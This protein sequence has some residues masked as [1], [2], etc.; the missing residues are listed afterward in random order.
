M[1]TTLPR[2]TDHDG[3]L[4]HE[5]LDSTKYGRPEQVILDFLESARDGRQRSDVRVLD[6]GCGRGS[7]VAWL[8]EA[9][10]DAWGADVVE[11]YLVAGKPFFGRRG[12]NPDRLRLIDGVGLPFSD[13]E[14]FDVVLSDQVIEHV[15]DLDAFV[16][17]IDQVSR[18]SAVGMHIFPATWR[19]VEPHLHQP[20]VHWFPKGAPRHVA[21][22][23]ATRA[24]LGTDY[25]A[26]LS[27]RDRAQI[28]TAFSEDETFYRLRRTVVGVFK[29]HGMSVDLRTSA[30]QKTRYKLGA[31][32]PAVMIPVAALAY[33]FFMQTY[34][35]T[36]KL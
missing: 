8:C 21:I 3:N 25:F 28:F 30:T 26:S 19:P 11:D 22:Y 20:L 29:V 1:I 35:T 6:L 10:W 4:K 27:I 9:G 33:S 17:G 34:L 16:A 24:G 23:L 12:W 18:R 7:R 36:V 2:F 5:P 31:Q 13:D 15:K 32:L 14:H